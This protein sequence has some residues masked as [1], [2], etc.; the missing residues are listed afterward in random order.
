MPRAC[1]FLCIDSIAGRAD[2]DELFRTHSKLWDR[3]EVSAVVGDEVYVRPI[4]TVARSN[5]RQNVRN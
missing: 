5:V 4:R 3:A 2:E 1:E